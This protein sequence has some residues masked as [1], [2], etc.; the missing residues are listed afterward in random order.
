MAAM[1]VSTVGTPVISRKKESGAI[2]LVSFRRSTPLS[3]G[4]RT[5]EIT[6][7]KICDSSLRLAASTLCATSTLWPSLRKGIS[8]N[9]QM[10]RSSSPTRMCTRSLPGSR[11]AVFVACINTSSCS[12]EF[13][14]EFRSAVFLRNHAD[15]P[16]VS[17]HDLIHD[18]QS[19]AGTTVKTGLQRLKY[20]GTLVGIQAGA[21]VSEGHAQA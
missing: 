3:P 4:M 19:Q 2:S 18:R 17:L 6:M 9:S 10:E 12:R 14:D 15:A 5:S 16:A 13:H 20:L 11:A 7:S 8:S 21:G 1:A